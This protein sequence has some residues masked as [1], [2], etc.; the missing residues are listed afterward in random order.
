MNKK[1]ISYLT[2]F[3]FALAGIIW[4]YNA[5]VTGETMY[6][7]LGCVFICLAIVYIQNAR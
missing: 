4:E 6:V 7:A 5:Y 2:A 3:L 1:N